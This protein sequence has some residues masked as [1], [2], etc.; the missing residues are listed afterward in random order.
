MGEGTSPSNWT[1]TV[2]KAG[3]TSGTGPTGTYAGGD[4]GTGKHSEDTKGDMLQYW[5]AGA[6]NVF[7]QYRVKVTYYDQYSNQYN[8]TRSLPAGLYSL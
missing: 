7:Y 3:V 5:R 6:G 8:G 2:T 1:V 4:I